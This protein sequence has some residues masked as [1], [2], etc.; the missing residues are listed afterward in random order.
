MSLGCLEEKNIYHC[1]S[2]ENTKILVKNLFCAEEVIVTKHELSNISIGTYL[3]KFQRVAE[4]FFRLQDA[5]S[6]KLRTL[7]NSIKI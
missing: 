5:W 2:H 3:T 7:L 4:Q 1:S 6:K